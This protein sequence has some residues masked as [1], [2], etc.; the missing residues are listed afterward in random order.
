[1]AQHDFNRLAMLTDVLLG[2]ED[3]ATKTA[4]AWGVGLYAGV[5]NALDCIGNPDDQDK[6]LELLD[7]I[8]EEEIQ[9]ALEML[10]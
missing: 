5:L 1:M 10:P 9:P 3:P 6:L 4:M 7:E 2:M 8:D